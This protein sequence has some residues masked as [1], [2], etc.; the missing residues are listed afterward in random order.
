MIFKFFSESRNGGE[1]YIRR[2]IGIIFKVICL[3]LGRVIEV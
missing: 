3:G 1:G 2:G